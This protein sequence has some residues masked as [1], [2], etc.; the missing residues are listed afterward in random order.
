M[1]IGFIGLGNMGSGM[2]VNLANAGYEVTGFD[3]NEA[4]FDILK[5]NNIKQAISLKQLTIDSD[6]I[7]T[8]LPNGLIVK[9]VWLELLESI[10]KQT[11]LVDCSTIDV[12]TSKEIQSLANKVGVLT[13][14][15]PVSGGVV[16]SNN[17]TL[18]FM[19]GGSNIAYDK[20]TPLFKIMGS[21]SVF[22]GPVGTGQAAKICNNML[23]AITMIGVGEA[24]NLG[25][26][27]GLDLNKLFDVIS[28]SSAS[29]WAVNT[30]CPI[31]NIGPKTPADNKYQ[32]GF[33]G[34]LMLKDLT[35]ALQALED[36]STPANF[37]TQAQ[38]AFQEMVNNNNGDLD[39]SAIINQKT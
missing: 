2:S 25:K 5:K 31:P 22:C 33:S 30:Y 14:D 35:L 1:K 28:T 24:F 3:R 29:C 6:I 16:G 34:N 26:N 38:N 39:F 21:K 17:G 8:M 18:T 11:I 9:K 36:T 27:L 13:L 12:K 20:I 15:A 32:P 19:I 7:F 4:V 37:G 23:L 10:K